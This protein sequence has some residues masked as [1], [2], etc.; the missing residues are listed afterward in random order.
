MNTMYGSFCCA[1]R[2]ARWLRGLAIVALYGL[3]VQFWCAEATLYVIRPDGTGDYP[4]IQSGLDAAADGDTLLL[5]DGVF[6]G[7]GNFDLDCQGKAVTVTSISGAEMCILDVQQDGRGFVF[8]GG[9]GRECHVHGVTIR[10]GSAWNADGSGILI[11]N[12]SSPTISE[13]A[14][15]DCAA[16]GWI[17]GNGGGVA[18]FDGSDPLFINCDF[19]QNV[20][21]I[22]SGGEYGGAIYVSHASGEFVG[23]RVIG[24]ASVVGGGIGL[25]EAET[26]FF[27]CLIA[28]NWASLGGGVQADASEGALFTRCTISGNRSTLD[29]GGIKCDSVTMHE[30]VLWGNC[31][32]NE[33]SH[34]AY[35]LGELMLARC[36]VDTAGVSGPGIAD[37]DSCLALDPLFCAPESCEE[38]PSTGGD[39]RV[40]SD[41][42]CVP[43]ENPWEVWIG[44]LGV[45]CPT[46]NVPMPSGAEPRLQLTVQ[47]NPLWLPTSPC[48]IQYAVGHSQEAVLDVVDAT[49]RMVV[50]L[51]E[52]LLGTDRHVLEWDGRDDAGAPVVR[53]IYW[54]RLGTSSGTQVRKLV[55]MR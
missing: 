16:T 11:M 29:G 48:R 39:W 38:A 46:S 40:N 45:G 53:G 1:S 10:R 43:I 20:G 5:T 3:V 42:P 32:S 54:I 30:T 26:S 18:I 24:N 21:G 22:G 4:T 2:S 34:Q 47:P 52:G 9:E 50:T 7:E 36:I 27:K 19:S 35:V 17:D 13:C 44:A 31:S 12:G 28:G 41:S 25:I 14:I 51:R 37:F 33:L 23:C 15:V 6:S 55:V 8:E 49:G